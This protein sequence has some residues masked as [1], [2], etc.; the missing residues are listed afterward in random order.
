[1]KRKVQS[2]PYQVYFL[3]GPED[4][5]IEKEIKRL[6]EQTLSQKERGLNL[7]LFSSK[8][9]SCQE[10]IQAAQTIPMFSSYRF[11]L[12]REMDQFDENSVKEFLEYLRNPS[13]KTFFVMSGPTLGLWKKYQKELEK[14]CKF[15][16]FPRLKSKA[17]I[18]WLK[19]EVEKRGKRI[20]EE[21]LEY[22]VSLSGDHLFDL[23]QE[24]EKVLL[25]IGEKKRIDISDVEEITSEIKISTI[26]DL[27]E[28]ISQQDL[29]K[30]LKILG[31]A[32]E[33]RTIPFKKDAE[34]P[35]RK[36]EMIA[37][38]LLSMMAKQYW[39]LLKVKKEIPFQ[40][41]LE[42]VAKRVCLPLWSV[43]RL[44]AQADKFSEK[45]LRRGIQ[46]CYE[47]D[48]ELK[49]QRSPKTLLMEKLV[50][51]LCRPQ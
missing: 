38:L 11:I 46:K 48:L 2:D 8:E 40:N 30:A 15:M 21:A 32:L 36:D 43:R 10:I 37:L 14:T 3:Y 6:L 17:L 33:S 44:S 4:Y 9:H 1:M 16:E 34:E 7:H 31:K 35:E 39:N 23:I 12:V 41:N 18:L 22:L 13:P 26:F 5:L 29:E 27:T 47:T 42:E 25:S 28:A 19:H 45:A 20:T 49:S 51:D 24:L 50:I